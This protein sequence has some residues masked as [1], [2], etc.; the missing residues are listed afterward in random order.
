M[1]SKAA[2]VGGKAS[3]RMELRGMLEQATTI[4]VVAEV[5][6]G[7]EGIRVLD[8][9]NPD[10]VLIN[11]DLLD[12]PWREVVRESV[13]DAAVI[14]LAATDRDAAAAFEAGVVD[15]VLAPFTA[16]RLAQAVGRAVERSSSR[17][18]G[19]AWAETARLSSRDDLRRLF[20]RG[21]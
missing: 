4:D 17:R 20:L 12:S 21:A 19:E 18:R 8:D 5:G 16:E 11:I 3:E 14:L 2:I 15:Y 10:I 13:H 1:R 6:G 9:I 7:R